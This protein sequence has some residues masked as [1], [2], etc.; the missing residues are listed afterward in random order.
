[1]KPTRHFKVVGGKDT[2]NRP[3]PSQDVIDHLEEALVLAK[4]GVLQSIV[5]VGIT[6]KKVMING[7]SET[8]SVFTMLGALTQTVTDYQN[9]ELEQYK[10]LQRS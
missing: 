2:G 7:W 8:D 3:P 10:P 4:S 1:M 6:D 5:L 9:R